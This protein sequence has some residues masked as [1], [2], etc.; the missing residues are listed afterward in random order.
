MAQ[1]KWLQQPAKSEL[2]QDRENDEANT[3][4]IWADAKTVRKP[5]GPRPQGDLAQQQQSETQTAHPRR[6]SHETMN[7]NCP[8]NLG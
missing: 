6:A 1:R 8:Q 3:W 7:G 2:W 4:S 5:A